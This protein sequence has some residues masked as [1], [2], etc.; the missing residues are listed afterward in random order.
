MAV[1]AACYWFE[2]EPFST[3]EPGETAEPTGEPLPIG[4]A[5]GWADDPTMDED[6]KEVS[7]MIK[8]GE[9]SSTENEEEVKKG[10]ETK[11]DNTDTQSNETVSDVIPYLE[12]I[13][14]QLGV[15]DLVLVLCLLLFIV[16]QFIR[17]PR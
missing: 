15:I 6:F 1:L 7:E 3:D 9:I 5:P 12:N 14:L 8:E 11:N 4:S 13:S 2:V 17:V 16:R 10:E